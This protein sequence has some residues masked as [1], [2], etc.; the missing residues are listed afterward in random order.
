[1]AESITITEPETGPDAPVVEDNQ[2]SERP[3]WLPEKFNSPEDL[4]K[5]YTE[6]EKKLS[7]PKETPADNEATTD[8]TPTDDN[9]STIPNFDKFSQEFA[10]GGALSEDSFAELE[11]MGYP[12]AMVETYIQGM[13]S[14]QEADAN[15]V[16]AV[17][18]GEDGYKDLTDWAR[19]NMA[20]NELEVYNQMVATGTDNA[21]MAVE[22]MMS[23]RE[24][25]GDVEPNLV[26]GKAQAAS[27]D[28]FRS[29]AQVV[30][31]MKDP[32]Y[33]KDAAYTK[34]VEQKLGRSSVF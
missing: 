4:A 7:A 3:D 6:L 1:M 11:Q 18:G 20:A 16:M 5:S 26:S 8:E 24:A 29:T 28:E 22:W 31:A 12:K 2:A 10:D 13:Q 23:K 27:K 34:D 30:A 9:E 32:R 25:A 14:T 33:G 19:D 15:T 21:K 17:A